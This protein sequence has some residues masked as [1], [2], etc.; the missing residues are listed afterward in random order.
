MNIFLFFF[1]FLSPILFHLPT[2]LS[3]LD[4]F[5]FFLWEYFFT[6]SLCAFSSPPPLSQCL[7]SLS[8]SVPSLSRYTFLFPLSFCFFLSLYLHSFSLPLSLTLFVSS[9]SRCGFSFSTPFIPLL[10]LYSLCLLSL[11]LSLFLFSCLS[12]CALFFP[13]LFTPFFSLSLSLCLVSL[14]VAFPFPLS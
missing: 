6:I 10:S 13:F 4:N 1:P 3:L 12:R 9:P 14:V 5:L 11:S 7:L 2:F 8:V